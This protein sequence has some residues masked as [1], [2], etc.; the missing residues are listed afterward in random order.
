MYWDYAALAV[1]V[2]FAALG[3]WRGTA[4]VLVSFLG[5]LVAYAVGGF[6][7]WQAGPY[8]ATRFSLAL[9]AGSALAGLTGFLTTLLASG[10][11][12][13]AV[14]RWD[15]ERREG[16][17][18][19][20][21]S[22]MD[23][24]GGAS[25]GALRG[26]LVALL[27]GI[28]ALWL[29]AAQVVFAEGQEQTDS[30]APTSLLRRATQSAI[31]IGVRRVLGGNRVAGLATQLLGNPAT[32]LPGLRDA[33]GHPRFQALVE[34]RRFWR[35]VGRGELDAAI[36]RPRFER[37]LR[38]AEARRRLARAGLIS[39]AA[40]DDMAL[41]RAEARELL[42]AASEL[43]DRMRD[44]PELESLLEDPQVAQLAQRGDVVGLLRHPEVIRLLSRVV[45]QPKPQRDS[46][47]ADDS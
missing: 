14:R 30:R 5:L 1:I 36:Q 39:A 42:A 29:D 38:D 28:S 46:E 32:A 44:A 25:L 35:L 3:A 22:A 8:F 23:R 41:L 15:R 47:T 33:T 43:T 11:L 16:R 9:P 7:A 27:L 4:V 37:L 17:E 31:G 34:D 20:G 6:V 45:L 19:P 26:G 13:I 10:A 2:V 21:R 40:V 24:F 18:V 12:G